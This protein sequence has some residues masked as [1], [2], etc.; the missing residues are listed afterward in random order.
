MNVGDVVQLNSGGPE[1]TVTEVDAEG[2]HT[3]WFAGAKREVGY[4]QNG[5]LRLIAKSEDAGG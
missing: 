2:V 3:T 5:T 1:M 4:F